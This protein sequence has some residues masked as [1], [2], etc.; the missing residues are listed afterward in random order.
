MNLKFH[1]HSSI[2]KTFVCTFSHAH[3]TITFI[4]ALS[5]ST[6]LKFQGKKSYRS[7]RYLRDYIDFNLPLR[8]KIKSKS[9]STK[10]NFF[11]APITL[12]YLHK[13]F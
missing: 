13:V 9:F 6:F 1:K 4:S 2:I 7:D 5:N 12:N 10:S 3:L 8:D 11:I